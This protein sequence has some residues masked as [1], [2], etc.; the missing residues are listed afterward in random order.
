MIRETKKY[1]AISFKQAGLIVIALHVFALVGFT[2]WSNHKARLAKEF[3]E[4]KKA[5]LLSETSSKQDWNNQH[6]KSKVVATAPT[7]KPTPVVSKQPS[8]KPAEIINGVAAQIKTAITS[9]KDDALKQAFLNTKAQKVVAAPTREVVPPKSIIKS[10][11]VSSKPNNMTT[12]VIKPKQ[13]AVVNALP[14]S[15]PVTTT[16]IKR[17]ETYFANG[18]DYRTEEQVVQRL[19]SHIKL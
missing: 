1:K 5:Q 4:A 2:Q 8:M 16:V 15:K 9:V 11:I 10:P 13:T 3:R 6:I 12:T 7:P 14:A 19:S 17:T 18:L